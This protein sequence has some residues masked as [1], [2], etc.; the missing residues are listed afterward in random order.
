MNG[1]PIPGFFY[2]TEKKKYFK[3]QSAAA[4]R[5]L[6]LEYS[7]E[8][9]RKRERVQN[10]QRVAA[11]RVRKTRRE[12]VVRRHASNLTQIRV[13]QEI[14]LRRQSAYVQ[15]TWPTACM[16]GVTAKPEE[17]L[18]RPEPAIQL[19]DRDPRLKAIFSIHGDNRIICND[20]E[21][22]FIRDAIDSH[23]GIDAPVLPSGYRHDYENETEMG[24]T[25]SSV[26]SISYL[27]VTGALA[28]TTYGHDTSPV[29]HLSNPDEDEP[30][31]SQQFI[32]K[33]CPAIWGAAPRPAWYFALPAGMAN[34]VA[35]TDREHLAVAAS[36]YLLMF[37]RGA[38]GTWRSEIPVKDLSSPIISLDWLSY[39][40][41]AMGCRDGKVLLYDTRSGGSS[42]ILTHPQ[43]VAKI[44]RADDQTRLVCAGLN[45]CLHL[46]DI[47]SP[48]PTSSHRR[49]FAENSNTH[50]NDT[51]FSTLD[52]GGP[53]RGKKRQKLDFVNASKW[54]QPL[55]TF[56]HSNLDNPNLDIAVHPQLGL[57]AAAQD[58]QTDVAIRVSNIW[59]GQVLREFK[60][61]PVPRRKGRGKIAAASWPIRTLKFATDIHDGELSL[62]TTWEGGIG[63]FQW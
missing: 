55:L 30:S 11:D 6:D 35:A 41:V 7:A 2:D 52:A 9:I 50:Y 8:N 49:P 24:R 63:R 1:Q 26:S 29:V 48:R 5:D 15:C 38:C 60:R 45:N 28:V 12:R 17:V 19:F 51:Y 33:D 61:D 46:Y 25:A 39:T 62:W 21:N 58:D 22:Q 16:S 56:E 54:S 3:I 37:T 40:T 34:T 13:E 53:L 18:S 59:T 47:R 14:G 27:P 31:V 42:H 44:K 43:P 23:V 10:I 4:S 32:P 57:L 20:L 36:Q